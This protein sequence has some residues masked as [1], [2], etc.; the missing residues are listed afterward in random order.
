VKHNRTATDGDNMKKYACAMILAV[1]AVTLVGCETAGDGGG[2]DLAALSGLSATEAL[3]LAN[4]WRSSNPDV[5]TTLKSRS[6]EFSF[7]DG[8]QGSVAI[9]EGVMIVAIAPYITNT[10]ACGIHSISGCTGELV[11]VSIRIVATTSGGELLFDRIFETL[12][13][14]FVELSLPSD[15]EIDLHLEYSALR[16][17]SRISTHETDNTC[18]TTIRLE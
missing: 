2:A 12:D 18:I 14:G 8:T 7:S 11:G 3:A 6:V 17:E 1:A 4:A 15:A 10:H 13:N 9:S 16:A 5:R